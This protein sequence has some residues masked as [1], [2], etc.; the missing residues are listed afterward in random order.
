MYNCKHVVNIL[1]FQLTGLR[2]SP[3]KVEKRER[4]GDETWSTVSL[5][6]SAHT[7]PGSYKKGKSWRTRKLGKLT[8]NCPA[9]KNTE[10]IK[11]DYFLINHQSSRFRISELL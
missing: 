9:E 8:V 10:F 4:S 1:L 5:N 6:S 11:S 2:I 3:E 7:T